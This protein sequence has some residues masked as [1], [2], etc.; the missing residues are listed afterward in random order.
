MKEYNRT[1]KEN[2]WEV[3]LSYHLKSS[4]LFFIFYD[5]QENKKPRF[6]KSEM[7][8]DLPINQTFNKS[9]IKNATQASQQGT[10]VSASA[11]RRG[12]ALYKCFT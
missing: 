6:K 3:E 8:G 7:H 2:G 9:S 4:L 11:E 1:K 10:V 12:G 5:D